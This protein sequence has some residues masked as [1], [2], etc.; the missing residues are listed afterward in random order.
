[1]QESLLI[2]EKIAGEH[3]L[4]V[5]LLE[6][7]T[8]REGDLA[9]GFFGMLGFPIVKFFA[10]FRKVLR[11]EGMKSR[12]ELRHGCECWTLS[13]LVRTGRAGGRCDPRR[14]NKRKS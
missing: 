9:K 4:T 11:V 6:E 2:Q 1:M 5:K 8:G 13:D 10:R 3:I 14:V 12:R 7:I